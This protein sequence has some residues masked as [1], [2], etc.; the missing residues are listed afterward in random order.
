MN[1]QYNAFR[2][3][4]RLVQ[5]IIRLNSFVRVHICTQTQSIGRGLI[6]AGFGAD[7]WGKTIRPA[8][9]YETMNLKT[10]LNR[11]IVVPAK[12]ILFLLKLQIY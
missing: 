8:K 3:F 7:Y 4:F 6:P 5:H 11:G 2:E 10:V 12:F 1:F 9:W